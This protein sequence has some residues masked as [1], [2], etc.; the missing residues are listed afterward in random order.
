MNSPGCR[1]VTCAIIMREQRVAGDVEGH[2]QEDV[3]RA[4]VELAGEPAVG[5]VELEQAVAGCQ[6]HV[7]NVGR[8]PGRDDDAAAV[9]VGLERLDDLGDLVDA[10]GRR[11][12]PRSAIAS[13]RPG[14]R[15]PFSSAHSSQIETPFAFR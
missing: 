12:R 11:A 1:P 13:R 4:L 5:D 6:R 14:P 7:G 9:R 8:V 2:A 15:S 10:C 3:G